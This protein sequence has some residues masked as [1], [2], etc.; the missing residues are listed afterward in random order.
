G[1]PGLLGAR[2]ANLVPSHAKEDLL[3][4]LE[5]GLGRDHIAYQRLNHRV[6]HQSKY[7]QRYVVGQTGLLGVRIALLALTVVEDLLLV[8]EQGL[9]RDHIAYQRLN[10]RVKHQS[11][12][13]QR[14]V[15]GQ[16][17][18]LGVRVAL[19]ALSVVEAQLYA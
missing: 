4:V 6:M 15:V 8:L 10:H 1:Q 16:T 9:G 14:Y 13:V 2:T 18:L 19:L 12:Y 3:L 11:K 7:V 17:G 5:Q